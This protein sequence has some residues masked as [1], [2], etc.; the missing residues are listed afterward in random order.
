MSDQGIFIQHMLNG[1]EM[2]FGPLRV[3]GYS[4][5]NG[6]KKAFEFLGCFYHGCLACFSGHAIHPLTGK[7]IEQMHQET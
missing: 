6:E 2:G 7:T 3:N 5:Q 4:Q 1:G